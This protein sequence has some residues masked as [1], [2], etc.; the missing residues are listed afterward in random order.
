MAR[1]ASRT[2]WKAL[3]NTTKN[4]ITNA[5][6]TFDAEPEAE[7][8]DEDRREHDARDRV[9]DLDVDRED[10]GEQPVAAERDADD[11]AGDR[12]DDEAEQRL[13][14]RHPEMIPERPF[15][16]ALDR[17]SSYRRADDVALG[18]EKKNGSIQLARAR[19]LPAAEEDD[20]DARSAR[21]TTSALARGA[22]CAPRPPRFRRRTCRGAKPTGGSVNGRRRSCLRS[23]SR[24]PRHA[25]RRS[26]L[27]RA[28]RSRS[29]AR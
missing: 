25:R 11:D 4:T 6:A 24:A 9:D 7:D 23:P 5:S 12:A 13:L 17:S 18:I 21:S 10:V 15:G 16:G 28:G 22:R 27:L 8:H 1:S 20:Q 19:Q 26:A 2:P 3:A 14:H 29:C